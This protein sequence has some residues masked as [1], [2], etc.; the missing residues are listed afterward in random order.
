MISLAAEDSTKGSNVYSEP[1]PES[2]S[3]PELDSEP[4]PEPQKPRHTIYNGC[5]TS[6]VNTN[7]L[8][9]IFENLIFLKTNI[10]NTTRI[11]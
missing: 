2:E 8:Q 5:Y 9:I 3:E 6:K 1:E 11:L 10:L 4:E 7:I